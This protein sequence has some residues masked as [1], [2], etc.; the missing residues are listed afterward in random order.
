MA[1][2]SNI[3]V[4]LPSQEVLR[5]LLDYDPETGRLFWKVRHASLFKSERDAK[6][7]N[8]RYAGKEAF[9]SCDRNGYRQATLLNRVYRAHRLIAV[10]VFGAVNGSIDHINGDREDNRES[11]LRVVSSSGN[12]RNQKLNA[13][14]TSGVSGVNWKKNRG[15]W[16]AYI[17]GQGRKN[18]HLGLFDTF[19]EAVAARKAAEATHHYH[20]NHGTSR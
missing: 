2:Q 12:Q 16:Q 20:E 11:N 17:S 7:W 15:K 4:E 14:N 13:R 19:D 10:M 8:T 6:I 1:D 5:S 3:P 18:I 9:T